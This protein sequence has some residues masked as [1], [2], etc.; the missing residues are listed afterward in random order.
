MRE[1]EHHDIVILESTSSN[2]LMRHGQHIS[3]C[4]SAKPK[5]KREAIIRII[6]TIN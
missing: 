2:P 3:K 4:A 1:Q 6:L 5:I